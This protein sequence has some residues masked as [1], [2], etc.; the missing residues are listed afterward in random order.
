MAIRR[1]IFATV[2]FFPNDTIVNAIMRVGKHSNLFSN[3]NFSVFFEI[4]QTRV[5]VQVL[6]LLVYRKYIGSNIT[7]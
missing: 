7:M 3:R 1:E 5:S 6:L 2:F 4:P